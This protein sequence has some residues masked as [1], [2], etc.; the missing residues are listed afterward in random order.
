MRGDAYIAPLS[1]HRSSVSLQSGSS[2]DLAVLQQDGMGTLDGALAGAGEEVYHS[3][4]GQTVSRSHVH[5][6]PLLKGVVDSKRR[7]ELLLQL[8]FKQLGLA[9]EDEDST[10]S[11]D[12]AAL[13]S[14][15][16]LF[17]I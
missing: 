15:A 1:C 4:D 7:D 5:S 8:R 13:R 3:L 9:P 11:D 12:T 17:A 14:E 6:I 10:G 2:S 16:A